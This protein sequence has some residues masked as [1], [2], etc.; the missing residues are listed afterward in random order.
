VKLKKTLKP[1]FLT[2]PHF[3][4][5]Q[6]FIC[7]AQVVKIIFFACQHQL[8]TDFIVCTLLVR[9]AADDSRD[10]TDC[11]RRRWFDCSTPGA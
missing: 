11:C 10:V 6:K 4:F 9:G 7:A 3:T 8:S 1:K 2:F 5:V